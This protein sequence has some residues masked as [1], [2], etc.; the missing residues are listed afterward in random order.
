MDNFGCNFVRFSFA[1]QVNLERF[2]I[3]ERSHVKNIT[4]K[5]NS[6]ICVSG[7]VFPFVRSFACFLFLGYILNMKSAALKSFYFLFIAH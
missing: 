3:D 7:D 4:L 5:K 2:R 6:S 1:P